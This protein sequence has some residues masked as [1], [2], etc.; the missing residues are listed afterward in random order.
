M[1]LKPEQTDSRLPPLEQRNTIAE[2]VHAAVCEYTDTDGFMRCAW[3]AIAGQGLLCH[4]KPDGREYLMSAGSA[5]WTPDPGKPRQKFLMHAGHAGYQRGEYH[6]ILGSRDGIVIDFS[7][8]HYR[9]YVEELSEATDGQAM[10]WTR[11]APPPYLWMRSSD[12]PQWFAFKPTEA[13]C[14]ACHAAMEQHIE[15]LGTLALAHYERL[16]RPAS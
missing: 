2:A 1:G 15:P 9:R 14:R 10:R 11:P 6:V 13:A 16:A 4:L 5:E 7:A 12:F 8:R 3:Y